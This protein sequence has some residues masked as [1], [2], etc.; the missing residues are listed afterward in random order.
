MEIQFERPDRVNGGTKTHTSDVAAAVGEQ[1][2][3]NFIRF[4]YPDAT[5]IKVVTNGSKS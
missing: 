5:N 2:A 3:K 4:A 1:A